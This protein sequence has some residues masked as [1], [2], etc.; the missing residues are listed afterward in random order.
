MN[1]EQKGKLIL[2]AIIVISIS[3]IIFIITRYG[4][5]TRKYSQPMDPGRSGA[6]YV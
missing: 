3:L 2:T 5:I 6:H 4:C 1:E